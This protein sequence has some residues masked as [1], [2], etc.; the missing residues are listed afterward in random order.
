M[1]RISFRALETADFP[2]LQQWLS[3]PH[4][5]EWWHQ[6]LDRDGIERKYGPRI[7]GTE[8]THVFIIEHERLSIGWVQ[9]HRWS[10]YPEHAVQL[11]V[12]PAAAGVDLAIGEVTLIGKGLG[13]RII[14]DFVLEVIAVQSGITSVVTDVEE[15]NG[16]SVRAFEKAGFTAVGLVQLNGENVRRRLMQLSLADVR[17]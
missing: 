16:R 11:K 5:D 17:D 7:N 14:R 9:W 8:P 12:P 1:G 2:S 3:N 10:D 13:P 4:I 6:R 15:R